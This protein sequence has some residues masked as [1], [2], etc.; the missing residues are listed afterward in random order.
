VTQIQK[1]LNDPNLSEYE[2][3]EAVKRQAEQMEQK[4]KM[5]EDLIRIG[6]S[7]GGQVEKTIAVNDMYIDAITAKL[8][9]LDQI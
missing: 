5:E 8:K 3:L 1:Y 4:A 2:R 6:G 9:I 7:N